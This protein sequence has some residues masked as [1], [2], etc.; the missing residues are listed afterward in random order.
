V[1]LNDQGGLL[2]VDDGAAVVEVCSAAG[3]ILPDEEPSR[4]LDLDLLQAWVDAGGEPDPELLLNAWNLFG[5]V[6][7]SV[8]VS[9]DDRRGDRDAVYNKLASASAPAGRK[10]AKERR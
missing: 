1:Q 5:D 9:L 7:R 2:A 8:G 6:A 10:P 3:L 4:P